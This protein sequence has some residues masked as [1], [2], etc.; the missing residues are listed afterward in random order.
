MVRP[1][2]LRTDNISESCAAA[3]CEAQQQ[4]SKKSSRCIGAKVAQAPVFNL[5]NKI[6][7]QWLWLRRGRVK[8]FQRQMAAGRLCGATFA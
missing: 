1:L 2:G 4:R 3:I 6:F 5:L 7:F 8:E